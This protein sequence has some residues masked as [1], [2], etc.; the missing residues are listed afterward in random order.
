MISYVRVKG[1]ENVYE[2]NGFLEFSFNQKA[3]YFRDGT[4]VNDD[5]NNWTSLTFSYPSDSSF[6]MVKDTADYWLINN[7][8]T[9]SAKAVNF[10]RTLSHLTGND[11]IDDPVQTF[12]ASPDYRL[13]IESTKLGKITLTGY[14]ESGKLVIRASQNQDAYFNGNTNSLWQKIFVGKDY[15]L[16]K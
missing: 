11:F 5:L 12:S 3:S 13:N 9:D 1:D 16:E 6:Q 10:L 14:Q 15:F 8:K 2:V 4:I 7:I